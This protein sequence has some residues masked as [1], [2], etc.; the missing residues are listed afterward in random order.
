[1]S[2]EYDLDAMGPPVVGKYYDA[3]QAWKKRNVVV[4]PDLTVEFPDAEGTTAKSLSPEP[5]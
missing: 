2:D 5:Q 4:D 1:M 3:Y